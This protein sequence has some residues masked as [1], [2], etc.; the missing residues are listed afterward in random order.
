MAD[1]RVIER[2]AA[3]PILAHDQLSEIAVELAT[4]RITTGKGPTLRCGG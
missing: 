1:R 2:V 4:M 3:L